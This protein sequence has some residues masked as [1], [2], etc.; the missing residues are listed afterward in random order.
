MRYRMIGIDM[1]GT[2]LGRGGK[3]SGENRRAIAR[4]HAA[5]VRIVPCTG[6]AWSEAHPLLKD[7]PGLDR[8]VFVGGAAVSDIASG[9][10]LDLAVFEP[11]LAS[12]L[13]AAMFELPEAVLVFKDAGLA[14][15]DYLVTGRGE[16]SANTRWW[17][18][19]TQAR[20]VFKQTVGPDDLHHALRIGIASDGRRMEQVTG[21]LRANFGSRVVMQS[22]A[23][24]QM[25]GTTEAMHV[26]E[27][28]ASGVDKWRGL[29]WLADREG[30]ESG[31]IAAIG[32]EINDVAMI[33][34]AGCGIAMGNAAASAKAVAR[35]VTRD[36]ADHGVAYAINQ[37][38]DGAWD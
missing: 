31:E 17:F 30:I 4:A 1:D 29:R 14:G 34:A 33:R 5:G 26:L 32:D 10:S 22:F 3:I 12:E 13:V 25:P 9:L 6:R 20:P 18:E 36:C 24:V 8:G 19:K 16:L 35:H 23:A 21:G 27:V 7:L 38:L 15:H 2:L 28:F 37:L 11:H